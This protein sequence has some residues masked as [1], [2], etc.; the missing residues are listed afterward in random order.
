MKLKRCLYTTV[1][2]LTIF[3]IPVYS[4]PIKSPVFIGEILE[5]NKGENGKVN[6]I[7]VDGYIKGNEVY[8]EKI[9][10]IISDETKILNSSNDKKEDIIIEKGD[11][12]YMRISEAM[13]KSIPPQSTIKR[14]FISKVV[15]NN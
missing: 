15:K 6:S 2:L 7:L 12:V 9:I 13:T 4:K 11:L 1:L 8:K 5:V 10:G 14:V 3:S